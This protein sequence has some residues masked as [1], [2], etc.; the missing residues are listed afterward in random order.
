M[1]LGRPGWQTGAMTRGDSEVNGAIW[2]R[3]A[4]SIGSR[5]DTGVQTHGATAAASGWDATGSETSHERSGSGHGAGTMEIARPTRAG[6]TT[7][8]TGAPASVGCR[9]MEGLATP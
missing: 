7:Q 3:S 8:S 5:I 1:P 2:R 6:R 9:D 4:E